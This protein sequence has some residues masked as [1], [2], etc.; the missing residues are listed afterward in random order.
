M[1]KRLFLAGTITFPLYL[2]VLLDSS[3]K[4]ATFIQPT[5]TVKATEVVSGIKQDLTQIKQGM[6]R[7]KRSSANAETF[8]Y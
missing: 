1:L 4:T 8:L 2:I 3:P 5:L 6:R 7:L